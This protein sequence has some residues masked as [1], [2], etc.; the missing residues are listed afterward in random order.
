MDTTTDTPLQ[1]QTPHVV[2]TALDVGQMVKRQRNGMNL[3]QLDVAGLA[4][5]GNRLIVDVEN[6]KPTVQLQKVLDLLD[7]L[8]LEVVIQPKTSRTL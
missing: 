2:R 7:I 1:D 3:R 5:T 8:G 4:N 6:G